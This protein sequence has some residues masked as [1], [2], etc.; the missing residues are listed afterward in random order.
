LPKKV[1]FGV[2]DFQYLSQE[3]RKWGYK[4]ILLDE[5]F[6]W[7]RKL[8]Q[9][10]LSQK[11]F[12]LKKG[13]ET[14]FEFCANGL[15]A[16]VWTT[17]VRKEGRFRDSDQ[18]WAGITSGDGKYLLYCSHPLNRTKNF[19]INLLRQAWLCYWRVKNRSSCPQ[20]GGLMDIGKGSTGKNRKVSCPEC[21]ALMTFDD[22]GYWVCYASGEHKT[23][24][25]WN[26]DS[27]IRSR[28]WV[29]NN[30]AR[31]QEGKKVFLDWD[32]NLP[33]K[34]KKYVDKLRKRWLK[35][36]QNRRKS[37]KSV[38]QSYLQRRHSHYGH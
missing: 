18:G 11:R 7:L 2:K 24:L 22:R 27:G 25:L 9:N 3:L 19:P 12:R 4:E 30:R 38:N 36:R 16:V 32:N 35:Y 15:R 31:H 37:G 1:E 34:A 17:W 14:G 23:R 33:P 13:Q 6:N 26:Y 8:R 28:F 20:C 29:C 5:F 21:G 10:P